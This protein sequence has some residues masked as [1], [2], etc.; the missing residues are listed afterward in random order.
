M[1]PFTLAES[2]VAPLEFTWENAVEIVIIIAAGT[3]LLYLVLQALQ[4]VAMPR[5]LEGPMR[6]AVKWIGILLIAATVLQRFNIP[7]YTI[8]ATTLAMVAVGFIAAWSVLCNFLCSFLLVI[9]KPFAVNDWVEFPGERIGGKVTDLTLLYTV[10]RDDDGQV[11]QVP[12]SLFFQKTIKRVVA[13]SGTDLSH[14][15]KA[16]TGRLTA[17]ASPSEQG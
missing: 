8:L 14:S 2:A 3:A 13:T 15:L 10:L 17:E 9:L 16:N 11:F 7:V 1:R 6:T 4:R 5:L 12:N